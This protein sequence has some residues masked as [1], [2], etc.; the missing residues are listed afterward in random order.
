MRLS[1]RLLEPIAADMGVDLGGGQ[2][3]VPQDLLHTAQVCA[4][5]QQVGGHRMPHAVRANVRCVRDG[6][7]RTV[8]DSTHHPLVQTATSTAEDGALDFYVTRAGTR[9]RML[10][11]GA[12]VSSPRGFAQGYTTTATAAGTTTLTVASTQQQFFT[13]STTQTVVLPVTS[14]LILGQ[15]FTVVNNSTGAVTVQ[16]SGANNIAIQPGGTEVTYVVI[17]TSG[18]T[19][20]SWS[21]VTNAAASLRSATTIVGVAAATAPSSGQVLTA[22]SSTAATWQTPSSGGQPIPS[23]ST[24][25][26]VGTFGVMR[27]TSGA[28]ADGAT[29]SGANIASAVVAA[30]SSGGGQTGTWTNR[31][32]G[33]RNSVNNEGAYWSRTA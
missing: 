5:L 15:S 19:A 29:A 1:E 10:S 16:S 18:T 12:V 21:V 27:L 17:L 25:W 2:R 7:H 30:T 9:T 11:V 4:T 26:A 3:G 32:G 23:A 13:G 24:N 22:T 20:A 6:P 14:T 31:S 8:D 28:V 33:T